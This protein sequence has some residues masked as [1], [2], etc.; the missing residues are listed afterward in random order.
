[1]SSSG[2]THPRLVALARG[3]VI[4]FPAHVP[5]AEDRDGVSERGHMEAGV[6][7][8]PSEALCHRTPQINLPSGGDLTVGSSCGW[9]A[10]VYKLTGHMCTNF[11]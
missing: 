10:M 5:A 2:Q 1:M 11:R 7:G 6:M 4:E 3:S 9:E 8:T